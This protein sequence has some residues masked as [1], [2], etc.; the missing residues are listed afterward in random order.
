MSS[1]GPITSSY[2][3][4]VG[5]GW[6]DSDSGS[7]SSSGD[8]WSGADVMFG[9]PAVHMTAMPPIHGVAQHKWGAKPS[10]L[11]D[12]D[13]VREVKFK[14][15]PVAVEYA[16]ISEKKEVKSL[17][18]AREELQRDSFYKKLNSGGNGTLDVV[19]GSEN[20]LFRVKKYILG[21][22]LGEGKNLFPSVP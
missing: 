18:E 10:D 4:V 3:G 13:V 12:S 11:Q 22:V 20:T 9:R 15:E 17:E 21:H 1:A 14:S 5:G 19:Y 2:S 6:Y 16:P 7:E 8:E